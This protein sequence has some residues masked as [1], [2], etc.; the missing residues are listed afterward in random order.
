[1]SWTWAPASPRIPPPRT[2]P[3]G[4]DG[5]A[6]GW[7]PFPTCAA[8]GCGA[9]PGFVTQ[10][11]VARGVKHTRDVPATRCPVHRAV[12]EFL[13]ALEALRSLLDGEHH[14]PLAYCA[15]DRV[16]DA[17]TLLA[18]GDLF[19]GHGTPDAQAEFVPRLDGLRAELE[20]A[21]ADHR[22]RYVLDRPTFDRAA[23]RP[24]S[25]LDLFTRS[26]PP[27]ENHAPLKGSL[28]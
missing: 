28:L 20:R 5:T 27:P 12:P 4:A 10:V 25:Q 3:H 6:Y 16:C 9:W 21:L 11:V 13:R 19:L 14:L 1:M 7:L 22:W 24:K 18:D 26:T 2:A 23:V 17:I 8:P 15:G